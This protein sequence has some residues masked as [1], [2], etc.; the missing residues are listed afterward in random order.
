MLTDLRHLTSDEIISLQANHCSA[1]DWSKILVSDDFT[2]CSYERVTFRGECILGSTRGETRALSQFQSRPTGI[3]H[4]TID[5]CIIEDNVYIAHIGNAISHYHIGEGT[6]IS[7]LF[8][9]TFSEGAIC[10]LGT[11]V[12]VLDETGGRSIRI[13]RS[14]SAAAA[15]CVVFGKADQGLQRAWNEAIERSLVDFKKRTSLGHSFIGKRCFIARSGRLTNVVLEDACMIEGASSLSDMYLQSKVHLQGSIKADGVIVSHDTLL[16]DCSLHHCY[17]GEG[18]RIDGGFSAHDS[19][20]F[21]NC[22]LSNGEV[23]ASFLGPH[24][25]TMHRST[26]LIGGA[27]SFFNAG[28]GTNQ[29]NHHYRLGPIHYGVLERGVKCSSDSY[30]LWPAHIGAFSKVVGR[31]YRH[32]ATQSFPFSLLNSNGG[33]ME[34]QPAVTIGHVGTWR[35]LEKWPQRDNRTATMPEDAVSY[36]LWQPAVMYSVWQGW[37]LLSQAQELASR[38]KSYHHLMGG[39]IVSPEDIAHGLGLYQALLY[40]YIG[41]VLSQQKNLCWEDLL[42]LLA[43]KEK[44]ATPS[45]FLDLMGFPLAESSY[46]NWCNMIQNRSLT[47]HEIQQELQSLALMPE[48]EF[49]WVLQ[50]LRA[51]L[52]DDLEQNLLHLLEEIPQCELLL[53]K[54]IASDGKK[55]LLASRANVG[56]GLLPTAEEAFPCQ[57]DFKVIRGH[58]VEQDF[59]GKLKNSFEEH[60][61]RARQLLDS[62][63]RF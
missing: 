48:E 27:F 36:S 59:V 44:G 56:F 50:L 18:C 25:V 23:A 60:I 28:S 62:L 53:Q 38:G 16:E 33:E 34:M 6:I 30:V 47:T 10:G 31:L 43:R 21:A 14:L 13:D 54:K 46:L 39:C 58:L 19:L 52:S 63:R 12:S 37:H 35:D 11:T 51:L 3:Y 5:H 1:T 9:L 20:I 57:A 42:D 61:K 32:P 41:R 2:P 8:S 55:E 40:A 24:T 4:A 15:Y 17:V 7:D 45:R 26:L 22:I 49:D 29:S